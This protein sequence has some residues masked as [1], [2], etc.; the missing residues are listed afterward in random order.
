MKSEENNQ[1]FL[2]FRLQHCQQC[3]SKT[4]DYYPLLEHFILLL[5]PSGTF[6]VSEK[7]RSKV[8]T[9]DGN[10]LVRH[11]IGE[12]RHMVNIEIPD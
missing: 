11:C 12:I 1:V 8:S 3:S 9:E 2:F 6:S 7:N 10:I 5:L 4:I